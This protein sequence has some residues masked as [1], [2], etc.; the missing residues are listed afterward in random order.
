MATCQAT[1]ATRTRS[2]TLPWEMQAHDPSVLPRHYDPD[3][4][5]R[6]FPQISA[7][8]H[9]VNDEDW[10]LGENKWEQ[11]SDDNEDSGYKKIDMTKKRGHLRVAPDTRRLAW[12]RGKGGVRMNKSSSSH[13]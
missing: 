6:M 5:D 3:E 12:K 1:T 4:K 9:I 8:P 10:G 11:A 13:A 2:P 7:P